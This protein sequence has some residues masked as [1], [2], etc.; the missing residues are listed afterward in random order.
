MKYSHKLSDGVHIL[1]YITIFAGG[2]L[3]SAAIAASIDSN[4]SLVRRLMAALV[5]AGLINSQP[6]AA[7]PT[8]ARPASAITLLDVY[9]A[10]EGDRRLLHVDVKTNPRCPVGANIQ[11]TLDQTYAAVQDAAETA[12][13]AVTLDQL[14]ADI[15]RRA[16]AAGQLPG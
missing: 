13:A 6:G 11:A 10:L 12:M 16:R 1:A 15:T 7:N 5:Q 2:D 4:P 9:R 3:S 14:T 8:L